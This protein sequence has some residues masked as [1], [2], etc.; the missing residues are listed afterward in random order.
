MADQVFG[1]ITLVI[2]VVAFAF[3]AL[4][5]LGAVKSVRAKSRAHQ[6]IVTAAVS[7]PALAELI[8]RASG[9][10]IMAP[11][12]ILAAQEKIASAISALAPPDRD[13]VQ[14]GIQQPNS[15][16]AT[17]YVTALLKGE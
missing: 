10:I 17:G 9:S 6:L 16:G 8:K 2:V 15:A 7:D 11:G 4:N 13:R 14:E 12:E 1:G 3:A 5:V